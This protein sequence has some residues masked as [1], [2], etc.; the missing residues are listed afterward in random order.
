M[1][2]R[3]NAS[4]ATIVPTDVGVDTIRRETPSCFV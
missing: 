1:P 3:P 2:S 4:P